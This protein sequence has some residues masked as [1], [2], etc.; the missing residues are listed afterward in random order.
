MSHTPTASLRS[1]ANNG[2]ANPT[3]DRVAATQQETIDRIADEAN[4][5]RRRVSGVAARAAVT[6]KRA[7]DRFVE[8]VG[9]NLRKAR[10][11]MER[12]PHATVG[13]AFAAGA[14]LGRFIRR[15]RKAGLSGSR[16][17]VAK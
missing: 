8:A 9:E 11:R 1:D 7:Q 4:G 17:R 16:A 6:A 3:M 5:V 14:L 2:A 12:N 15:R 10:S 13:I